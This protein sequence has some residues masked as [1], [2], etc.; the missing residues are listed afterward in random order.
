MTSICVYIENNCE[1]A[2]ETINKLSDKIPCFV[3]IVKISS[4][5]SEVEVICQFEDAWTVERRLARFV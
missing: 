2:F 3:N 5:Y 1:K 4:T